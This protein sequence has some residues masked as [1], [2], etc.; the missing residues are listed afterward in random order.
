MPCSAA[1][2]L[3]KV[4]WPTYLISNRNQISRRDSTNR[5]FLA[6]A[7]VN[8]RH[9][10]MP[11]EDRRTRLHQLKLEPFEVAQDLVAPGTDLVRPR[12]GLCGH[13]ALAFDSRR[14]L[15]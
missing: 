3:I 4:N 14:R 10:A 13:G 8:N 5:Q 6:F 2:D 11:L 9:G 12:Y 7:R 15:Q 1:W